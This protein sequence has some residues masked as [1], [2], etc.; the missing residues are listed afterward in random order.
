MKKIPAIIAVLLVAALL[1]CSC[2]NKG[3]N[4][5]RELTAKDFEGRWT[6]SESS[7]SGP[8]G[9]LTGLAGF[10]VSARVDNSAVIVF[11]DGKITAEYEAQDGLKTVDLGAYEVSEGKL[12]INGFRTEPKLEGRKLTLTELPKPT[13]E[14]VSGQE[15]TEATMTEVTDQG[16]VMILEKK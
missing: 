1:L 11:K 13:G 8:A 5:N 3:N 10:M 14:E 16:P 4:E 12:F 6:M 7:T 9:E 15:A 2:G